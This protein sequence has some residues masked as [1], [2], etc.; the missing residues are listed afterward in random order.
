MLSLNRYRLK[1]LKKN[2]HKG[3]IKASKLLTRTDQLISVILIGN[4]FVNILASSIATVI[5]IRLWGDTGIAIATAGLTIILLI[6]AEIT[7]KTFAAYYPEKIALPASH[8]LKPLLKLLYP[9]V[10]AIN[11]I[12]GLLLKALGLNINDNQ[13]NHL[14]REELRTLVDESGALIPRKH[15]EMLVGILDLEKVTVTD[16]MIPR[17]EIVGINIDDDLN[18]ILHQLKTSQYTRLPVYKGDINNVIGILHLRN[19]TRVMSNKEPSKAGILQAC[20]DPYFTPESTSLNA[21]LLQ[22]QQEKRRIAIVV[23]EYGDALGIVTMEDILEEIVGEFTTDFSSSSSQDIIPQDDG[24]YLIDGS[25]PIRT[26]NKNLN[27]SLPTTGP[28]TLS[29][30]I[31]EALETLPDS[32]VCLYI[33]NYQVEIRQ[34]KDNIVKTIKIYESK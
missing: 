6:F 34:L 25:T 10:W 12:T 3:A 21:Q 23:D 29:G 8:I 5:A 22:F 4:N 15:Q 7:P 28:K 1:H 33:N 9:A 32:P 14:S 18:T 11:L 16:I 26:I 2:G 17:N 13:D 24:S 31:T 27:W 30:L 20:R 19:M